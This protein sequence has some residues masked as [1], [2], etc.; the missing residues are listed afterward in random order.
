MFF[1]FHS[2]K[3][4]LNDLIKFWWHWMMS[5]ILRD[6]PNPLVW[7]VLIK[8]MDLP[9]VACWCERLIVQWKCNVYKTIILRKKQFWYCFWGVMAGE[10]YAHA[11]GGSNYLCLPLDPIFDKIT[12]GVQGY[13]YVH[14]TEY[15]IGSHINIPN[16]HQNH[17]APCAV[18]YIGSRGSHLVDTWP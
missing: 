4:I 7:V 3:H 1:S 6:L 2:S 9:D 16:V 5:S 14:G 8:S 10:W 11:G 18:C 13:S 12:P 17:D 15:E